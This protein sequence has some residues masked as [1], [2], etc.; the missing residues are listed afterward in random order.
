MP[1]AS[2]R[3]VEVPLIGGVNRKDRPQSVEERSMSSG[4]PFSL[5]VVTE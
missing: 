2:G 3:P 4:L 5:P 1:V